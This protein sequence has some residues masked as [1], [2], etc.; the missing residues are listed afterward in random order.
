MYLV[1]S[2]EI[3]PEDLETHGL[4]V[5]V[6]VALLELHREALE[7]GLCLS[8]GQL[9]QPRRGLRG[10]RRRLLRRSPGRVAAAGDGGSGGGGREV[11]ACCPR[12][13]GWRKR[14]AIEKKNRNK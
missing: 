11:G 1:D 12:H 14:V 13:G 6:L 9:R 5:V 4:L 2:L 3:S 10:G 7:Q 8:P